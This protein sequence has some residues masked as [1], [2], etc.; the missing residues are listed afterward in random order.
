[1]KNKAE[2]KIKRLN[3]TNFH[4]SILKSKIWFPRVEL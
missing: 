1:M 3:L 2:K 4:N